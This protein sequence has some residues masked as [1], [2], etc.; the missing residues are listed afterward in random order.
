M[1]LPFF[2]NFFSKKPGATAGGYSV[3]D[4]RNSITRKGQVASENPSCGVQMVLFHPTSIMKAKTV[5]DM[6]IVKSGHFKP[7]NIVARFCTNSMTHQSGDRRNL[8]IR[9]SWSCLWV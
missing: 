5:I 9:A 3:I 8:G 4:W 7:I 6:P 1:T 2:F